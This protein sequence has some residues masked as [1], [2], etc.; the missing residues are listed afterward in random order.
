VDNPCVWPGCEHGPDIPR[1][2]WGRP[3][4]DGESYTRVSTLAKDISSSNPDG[5]MTWFG[6]RVAEGLIRD[7]G[8]LDLFADALG[9]SDEKEMKT[10]VKRASTIGGR[11]VAADRGTALHS[12][13][14]SALRGKRIEHV[15]RDTQASIDA[16]AQALS[17]ANLQAVMAEQFVRGETPNGHLYAGTY[18]LLLRHTVTGEW[19]VGDIKTSAKLNDRKYPAA[20]AIQLAA[21]QA[22]ARWCPVNGS[23]RS[24]ATSA[25]VGWLL[26][27]PVDLGDAYLDPV[28]LHVGQ[29][30]LQLTTEVRQWRTE[31]PLLK[32]IP[33]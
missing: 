18:D 3:V 30:G 27:V 33:A 16:A 1:D 9:R 11:D 14:A 10:L 15:D 23:L 32:G 22:G 19:F 6:T 5:L 2:R 7:R 17:D 12:R 21:Y 4:I 29:A 25:D 8:L 26:S 13:L 31:K 28:D 20:V 24:P